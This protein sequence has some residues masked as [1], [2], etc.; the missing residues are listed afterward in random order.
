MDVSVFNDFFIALIQP[1][2]NI[3]FM[4]SVMFFITTLADPLSLIVFS[5]FFVGYLVKKRHYIYAKVSAAAIL[6]G[7]TSFYIIKNL[8]PVARPLNPMVS[9]FGN[10]F[11][12]GHTTMTTI[13]CCLVVL[14]LASRGIWRN[15]WKEHKIMCL[16][17]FVIILL[18]GLSRIY[19]RAHWPI[20]I[21]GGIV[22]GLVSV[23]SAMVV[24]HPIKK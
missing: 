11:P 14:W 10:S 8:V 3:P 13:F 7:L 19:L 2:H 17:S 12:S 5:I 24:F 22:T 6:I 16:G 9:V 4:D 1:L 21:I 18:V 15:E 20:D 23:L